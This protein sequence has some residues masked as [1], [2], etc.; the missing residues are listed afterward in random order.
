MNTFKIGE[1]EFGIGQLKFEISEEGLLKNLEISGNEAIF[2]EIFED[3]KHEWSWILYPPKIYFREVNLSLD[4]EIIINE[5]L[6]D[7]NEIGLYADA[8]FYIFGTLTI[9]N[10]FIAIKAEV[11]EGLTENPLLLEIYIDRNSL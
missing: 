7:E 1:T 9:T 2:K 4:K 6:L 5:E 11:E 10:E 3:E 8:H